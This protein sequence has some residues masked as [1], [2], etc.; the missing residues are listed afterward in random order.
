MKWLRGDHWMAERVE[1]YLAMG[2]DLVEKRSL[3]YEAK[4]KYPY[5]VPVLRM[6]GKFQ[7]ISEESVF[8]SRKVRV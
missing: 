1:H 7:S 4:V 8:S 5:N 6:Y 3:H 2:V